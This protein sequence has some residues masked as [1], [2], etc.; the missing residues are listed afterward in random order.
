[1][2]N[3]V[4]KIS[5]AGA[6]AMVL[7]PAC[8]GPVRDGDS[9]AKK[10]Y[11]LLA[12]EKYAE[13]AK[14]LE[15]A[16]QKGL[17]REKPEEVYRCLGRAYSEMAEFEKSKEMFKKSIEA[18]PGFHKPWVGLGVVHR[19]T[20]DYDEA[21]RCYLKALELA[22]DYAEAHASI[23]ALYIFQEKYDQAVV[24][25]EKSV[26]LNNQLPVGWSNLALAYATVGKF[27]KAEAALKKAVILGYK[28]GPEIQKR[29]DNL[30][31]L[32]RNESPQ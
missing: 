22:P 25:L 1:M 31:A 2:S 29:I 20:G 4:T 8:R 21:E 17:S 12:A 30:K 3:R 5:L 19:L 28:S 23:G 9:R 13:A 27:E 14:E 26:E 11:R 24:H 6:I 7:L 18:N 32:R 15:T 16:L 10:G